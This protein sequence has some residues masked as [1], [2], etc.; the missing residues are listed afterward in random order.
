MQVEFPQ[1]TINRSLKVFS[2]V[3]VV[4]LILSFVS[5]FHFYPW[6]RKVSGRHTSCVPRLESRTFRRE[7]LSCTQQLL[8]FHRSFKTLLISKLGQARHSSFCKWY[9]SIG[10]CLKIKIKV[11]IS[12]DYQNPFKALIEISTRLCITCLVHNCKCSAASKL[13]QHQWCCTTAGIH[14]NVI[15]PFSLLQL[16]DCKWYFMLCTYDVQTNTHCTQS[17]YQNGILKI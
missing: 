7:L 3:F 13:I 4:V 2:F 5:G 10:G 9:D 1:I 8:P 15:R 12:C 17:S 14:W 11:L 16:L 6:W